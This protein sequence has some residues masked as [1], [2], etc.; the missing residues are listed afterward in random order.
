[1]DLGPVTIK[2][3][4]PLERLAGRDSAREL[5]NLPPDDRV[6]NYRTAG[7]CHRMQ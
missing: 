5:T 7:E 1:M 6:R 2:A 4:D 3:T